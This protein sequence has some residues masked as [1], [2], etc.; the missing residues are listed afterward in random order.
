MPRAM[1][2]AAE[3]VPGPVALALPEDMLH[4]EVADVEPLVYPLAKAHTAPTDIELIQDFIWQRVFFQIH[5][6][7]HAV[8]VAFVAHVADAFNFFIAH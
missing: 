8:F 3:G 7:A 1:R 5:D 2:L 4:D 6:H